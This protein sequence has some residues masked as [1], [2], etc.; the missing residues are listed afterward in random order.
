MASQRPLWVGPGPGS[1]DVLRFENI[2]AVYRCLPLCMSQR[3]LT[4]RGAALQSEIDICATWIQS[5]GLALESWRP[6]A[7][8][9]HGALRYTISVRNATVDMAVSGYKL[10]LYKALS[11][12][13]RCKE[14]ARSVVDGAEVCGTGQV[15]IHLL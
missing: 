5:L 14:K 6:S 10:Y 9:A 12:V 4:H 8:R 2:D 3:R 13:L 11:R 15:R 1:G 7:Q